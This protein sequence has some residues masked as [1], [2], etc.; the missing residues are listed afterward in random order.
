MFPLGVFLST[1]RTLMLIS[2]VFYLVQTM[3]LA[4]CFVRERNN[5][6][7]S[8]QPSVPVHISL[9]LE[10]LKHQQEMSS[11]GSY[12]WKVCLPAGLATPFLEG[13]R[14]FYGVQLENL[15]HLDVPLGAFFAAVFHCL[16]F[17]MSCSPTPSTMLLCFTTDTQKQIKLTTD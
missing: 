5:Y 13:C 11:T 15:G 17:S 8:L 7:F 10:L 16:A 1:L 12:M 9:I 6:F 4:L 14:F 2:F 3:A